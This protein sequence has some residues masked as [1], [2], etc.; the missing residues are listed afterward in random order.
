VHQL[1]SQMALH[2]GHQRYRPLRICFRSST[3]KR[4]HSRHDTATTM[5]SVIGQSA[6]RRERPA[7]PGGGTE[8]VAHL[9]P[10]LC[11]SA[12]GVPSV[13]L[14]RWWQQRAQPDPSGRSCSGPLSC[15]SATCRCANRRVSPLTVMTVGL[16]CPASTTRV[17]PPPRDVSAAAMGEVA[18]S[19]LTD[20][21][22]WSRADRGP[23]VSLG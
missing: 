11:H 6:T 18:N 23:S 14:C 1:S 20:R 12:G 19:H 5:D 17:S 3:G 2:F 16:P 22:R 4:P 8:Q 7:R 13:T 15:G 21:R 10:P 9:T